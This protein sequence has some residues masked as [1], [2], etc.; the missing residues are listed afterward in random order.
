MTNLKEELIKQEKQWL[1]YADIASSFLKHA[2]EGK[3]RTSSC[4]G[5][6]CQYYYSDRNDGLPVKYAD[7]SMQ[8][9]IKK[10]IQK[11]YYRKAL[12]YLDPALRKIQSFMNWYDPDYLTRLYESLPSARK[13][14][15]TPLAKT[16]SQYIE[17]WLSSRHSGDTGHEI[18]ETIFSNKGEAVRSKSEKII[19]D[20]LYELDIPYVYECPYTLPGFGP[21]YP[22]FTIL[23]VRLR[24]TFFFEHFGLMSNP[25]Y[26]A[27]SIRKINA[28]SENGLWF[29]DGLL[30]TFESEQCPLNTVFLERIIHR[31]L[32]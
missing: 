26:A 6:Y 25:D 24:K 7:A 22:D 17:E 2:P 31:F 4:R 21:V 1:D 13:S 8:P 19:A 5:K 23:N 15:L 32:L 12:D 27:K 11:E 28:Y 14:L 18:K 9:F 10:L 30:F 16:D 20:K 29:G 3:V